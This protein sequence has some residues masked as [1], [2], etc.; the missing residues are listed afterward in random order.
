M[1]V[2]YYPRA[3]AFVAACMTVAMCVPLSGGA[4]EWSA[5]PSL[6]FAE[7]YHDN[8]S[9]TTQPHTSTRANIV[10]PKLDMGVRSEIWRIG[11]TAQLESRRYPGQSILDSDDRLFLL[12]SIYRTERSSWRLNGSLRRDSLLTTEQVSPD[13][14][15]LQTQK[16]RESRSLNPALSWSFTERTQI[17]LAY[18]TDDVTY[19][20]GASAGLLDYQ[21]HS[22]TATLSNQLSPTDQ[23]FLSAGYS[24]YSVPATSFEA[25]GNSYQAGFT[26]AFSDTLRGTLAVG[27]RKTDSVAQRKVTEYI[28]ECFLINGDEV[29]GYIPIGERTEIRRSVRRS[30]VLNGTL[31]K[32]FEMTR[33]SMTLSRTLDPSGTGDLIETDSL[34]L[35]L[36]RP[37]TLK[38]TGILSAKA[39]DNRSKTS[40]VIGIDRK[41]YEIEPKLN[42]QWT[43]EWS[44]VT[45]YRHVHLKRS[46]ETRAVSGNTAYLSVAY[47]WP[48]ISI[49][50]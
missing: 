24:V 23:V 33:L 49:S 21:L 43:R 28:P 3:G 31:E 8:P 46:S 50:R 34:S 40:N 4:A 32:Q 18:Q 6:R 22:T 13:T 15:L 38:L 27:V 30:S 37:M 19:K 36:E 25:T 9:L 14:G 47:Q 12:A 20:D 45:S 48:K 29:C 41:G 11:G 1:L 5:E 10:S 17:Q 26:S 35:W 7:G 16:Q 42:W 39:Y 2:R 44:A